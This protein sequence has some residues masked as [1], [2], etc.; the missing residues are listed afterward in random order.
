MAPDDAIP[1]VP[2]LDKP[3]LATIRHNGRSMVMP[4]EDT[5]KNK[6]KFERFEP[7]SNLKKSLFSGAVIV[8]AKTSSNTDAK[9]AGPLI[10]QEAAN[11]T[12]ITMFSCVS[13]GGG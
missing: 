12:D 5:E 4:S 11:K 8:R 6:D 1:L 13:C 2:R 9:L 3:G 7:F 10:A